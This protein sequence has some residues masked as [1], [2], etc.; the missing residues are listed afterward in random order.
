VEGDGAGWADKQL[1]EAYLFTERRLQFTQDPC[2][3]GN[4]RNMGTAGTS[5]RENGHQLCPCQWQAIQGHLAESVLLHS[6][7]FPQHYCVLASSAS[8]R[9]ICGFYNI[10]TKLTICSSATFYF[11]F[12]CCIECTH[13]P[14]SPCKVPNGSEGLYFSVTFRNPRHSPEASPFK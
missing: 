6:Y 4:C 9:S 2:K 10:E 3:R 8:P 5:Y 1:S 13:S 12:N 7:P 14:S 11:C